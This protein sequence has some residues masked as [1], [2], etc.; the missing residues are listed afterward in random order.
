MVQI[1]DIKYVLIYWNTN[2]PSKKR[3]KFIYLRKFYAKPFI[4]QQ[5]KLSNLERLVLQKRTLEKIWTWI[6]KEENTFSQKSIHLRGVL[7]RITYISLH[8]VKELLRPS[9]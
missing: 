7:Y 8:T 6:L 3:C 1:G 2:L 4:F 9:Y 5:F